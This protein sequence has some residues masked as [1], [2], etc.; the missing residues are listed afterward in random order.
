MEKN[1]IDQL[2]ELRSSVIKDIYEKRWQEVWFFPSYEKNPEIQEVK[3]Y[4][5][6]DTIFF[7]SINPSS[8][9]YPTK[10]DISYYR[11]LK[12][13]DFSNAHLTDCFKIKKI[14]NTDV[15]KKEEYIWEAI[16]ILNQEISIINPKMIVLLGGEAQKFFKN[17]HA[18]IKYAG[19]VRPISHYSQRIPRYSHQFTEEMQDI[20]NEYN[21]I[22]NL[23]YRK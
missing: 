15:F 9:A 14:D 7:V 16:Q 3:G 5:G 22:T 11:S 13:H 20:R 19:K 1:K 4:L 21:N 23:I 10:N 8:G 18:K 12:D 2:L 17:H 6:T